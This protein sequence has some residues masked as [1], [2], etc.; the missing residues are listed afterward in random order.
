MSISLGWSQRT[1]PVGILPR[2]FQQAALPPR[3]GFTLSLGALSGHAR[4][5]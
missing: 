4:G 5:D 1:T 3:S 2:D